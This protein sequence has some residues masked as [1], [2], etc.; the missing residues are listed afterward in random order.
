M[1]KKSFDR[2]WLTACKHA[3]SQHVTITFVALGQVDLAGSQTIMDAGDHI[4]IGT[5]L[6]LEIIYFPHVLLGQIWSF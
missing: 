4:G 1:E 5:W 3:P 6:T 2:P